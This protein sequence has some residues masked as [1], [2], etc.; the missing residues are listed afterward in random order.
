MDRRKFLIGVG[1]AS[2]GGSA[3]IGSGAFS[4]A[5]SQRDVTVQVAEDPD[6]YLGLDECDSVHG[7]NY[8]EL[9]EKGHLTIDIGENPNDGE[10][11]NSDSLTWLDNVFEVC[12]QGKEDVCLW[13][14]EDD[15]WPTTDDGDPRVDFYLEDRDDSILGADNATLLELG[16]CACVGIQTRTHSVDA[17]TDDTLLDDIG[18]TITLVADVSAPETAG[19]TTAGFGTLQNDTGGSFDVI[20]DLEDPDLDPEDLAEALVAEG[21]ENG[22]IEIVPGSVEFT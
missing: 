22:D 2:I 14:V 15:D 1:G 4:R 9:D 3:I 5:Q 16:T 17:T 11:V 18:D 6:A 12:N 13:V 10:G 19:A 7:D 8:T 21:I 20:T